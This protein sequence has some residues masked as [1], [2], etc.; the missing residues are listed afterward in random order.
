MVVEPATPVR[1][2]E[3]TDRVTP[4]TLPVAGR[5]SGLGAVVVVGL[6]AVVVVVAV[7]E[8]EQPAAVT[9]AAVRSAAE[10]SG[11]VRG[12]CIGSAYRRADGI[13]GLSHA[14]DLVVPEKSPSPALRQ[15]SPRVARR[16]VSR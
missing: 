1:G 2:E 7:E 6:G 3:V 4:S 13:S 15:V 11:R 8:L 14:A 12:E 9:R 5:S 10:A 16:P